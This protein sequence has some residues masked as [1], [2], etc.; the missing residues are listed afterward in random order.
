MSN[1]LLNIIFYFVIIRGFIESGTSSVFFDLVI[2]NILL[3]TFNIILCINNAK[4]MYR[5]KVQVLNLKKENYLS[6]RE[7]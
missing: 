5:I 3:F 2:G 6:V 1:K 7:Y 4:C